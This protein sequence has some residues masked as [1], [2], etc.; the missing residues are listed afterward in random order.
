[1]SNKRSDN[2]GVIKWVCPKCGAENQDVL[3]E[4]C[5]PLCS[6][7]GADFSWGELLDKS[8]ESAA[9]VA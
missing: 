1:M 8:K 9:T 7:C 3:S 6:D 4:T 2:M 5:F